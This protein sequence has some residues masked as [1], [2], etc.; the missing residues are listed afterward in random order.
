MVRCKFKVTEITQFSSSPEAKR[1]VLSAVQG[2]PFGKY[3]PS[4]TITMQIL[5]PEAAKQIELG[6]EYFVDFTPVTE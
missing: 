6:K 1:V 2:E 4:G 5:N 3:T